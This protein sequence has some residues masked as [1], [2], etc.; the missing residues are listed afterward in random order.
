MTQQKTILYAGAAVLVIA[1][2]IVYHRSQRNAELDHQRAVKTSAEVPVELVPVASRP[3]R[4]AIPFTGTLLAVNRAELKAEVSGRLTR[5]TVQEG[6]RVKAGTVL[7]AQDEDELLLGVQT[8]EAQLAQA[9]AQAAQAKADNDRAQMLLAKHSVTRQSAQQAETNFNATQAAAQAAESNLGL[10]KTRLRKARTLAPFDGEVAQRA[11]QP[12]ENLSPGQT[13][14]VV[15]DNRKLEILADLPTEALALVKV[16]MKANFSVAGFPEP[17]PA[18][19]TQISPSVQQDGRTLRVRLEVPNPGGR[20]KGGLFAEGQ[21]LTEGTLQRPALPASV[22][23]T[24]GREADLFIE[25]KGFAVRKRVAVGPEQDGWRPVDGL[26]LGTRVVD[27]GRDQVLEG[28][29]LRVAPA[30]KGN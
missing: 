25:D 5:V 29:R 22:L 17:F 14:F 20:L 28:S 9:R 3:F 18:T 27:K 23:V 10:A 26:A 7:C 8:A 6:D 15:V 1:G 21:I 2:S 19:L 16:G 13:S 24:V 11:V 4:G 12:G 30:Q